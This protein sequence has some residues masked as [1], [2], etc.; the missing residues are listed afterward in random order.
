M[1]REFNP[2]REC[3]YFVCDPGGDGFSYFPTEDERDDFAESCIQAYLDDGWDE[4][5]ENVV[6]GVMTHFAKQVDRVDRPPQS[7]I[8]EE[9]FDGEGNDWG[10][11]FTFLCRYELLPLG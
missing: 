8:D 10:N 9:G 3:P 4:E 6:A 7:E 1:A 5:V 11:D 2:S